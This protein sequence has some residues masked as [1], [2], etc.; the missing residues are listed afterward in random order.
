MNYM[1]FPRKPISGTMQQ[2]KSK[3]SCR[4]PVEM[5]SPVYAPSPSPVD[6]EATSSVPLKAEGEKEERS[7]RMYAGKVV[8]AE[9]GSCMF[10]EKTIAAEQAGAE[11]V[12]IVNSEVSGD[13]VCFNLVFLLIPSN[14]ANCLSQYLTAYIV[15]DGWVNPHDR[16]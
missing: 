16:W 5:P 1:T 12:I 11:A 13:N 3:E 6:I 14:L 7:G 15:H 2:L 4:L 8:V 9:R 10:E